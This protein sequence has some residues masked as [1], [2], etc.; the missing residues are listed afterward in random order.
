MSRKLARSSFHGM[1]VY[2]AG[3]Q[4]KQ[5]FLFR[6]VDVANELFA[7]AASVTRAQALADTKQPEASEAIAIAD[8]FCRMGR[9]RIRALF[10]ELWDNDDPLRYK[11]ALAILD[12]RHEWLERGTI[13]LP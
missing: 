13:G 5:A 11:C 8:V 4:N 9:R 7:M 12:D 10:D 2:Q 3:L 1:A 6:L